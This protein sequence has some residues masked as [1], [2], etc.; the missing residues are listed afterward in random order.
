M[1]RWFLYLTTLLLACFAL[2]AVGW[3]AEEAGGHAAPSIAEDLSLWSLVAFLVFFTMCLKMLGPWAVASLA[4]RERMENAFIE[5]AEQKNRLAQETL[6]EHRGR[7]E[8][9]KEEIAERIA[10]AHR[11]ADHTR[12]DIA[13]AAQR[14]AEILRDR[15][16]SEIERTRCQVLDELF[17]M[18]ASRVVEETEAK[19]KERVD[20]A[21]HDRLID[22]SLSHFA[23]V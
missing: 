11:D 9:I 16:K 12:E 17:S 21:E 13:S 19:L 4:E 20:A 23:S 6:R 1:T 15:S 8:A 7:M 14:E 5:E 3:P 10:E 22:E 2:P 18:M